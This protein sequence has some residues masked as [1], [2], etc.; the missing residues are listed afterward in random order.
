MPEL[1][2]ASWRAL[3]GATLEHLTLRRAPAGITATG[4]IAGDLDGF[5]FGLRYEVGLDP[6]WTFRRLLI[7]RTDGAT[8]DLRADDGRWSLD[9]G[10]PLPDLAGCI[11][12]DLEG[13]PFTN[14]LPINRASPEPGVPGHF[15]MAYVPFESLAPFPDEQIYT[16]L[17][18]EGRYRYQAGDGSFEAELSVDADGLVLAYPPLFE[19]I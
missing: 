18:G 11:D 2:H 17:D 14:A 6:D 5:A 4:V 16:A 10:T 15:R 19:R 7:E 8:L 1:S 3:D 13:S 9:D 12:V